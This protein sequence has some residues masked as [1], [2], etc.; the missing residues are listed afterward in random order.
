MEEN[1]FRMLMG[2]L[3]ITAQNIRMLHR[4]LVGGNWFGD[5][6]K[7][8]EYYEKIDDIEDSVTE[9]GLFL[10]Y[11]D[12]T[13]SEASTMFTVLEPKKFTCDEAFSLVKTYFN[14]I[15]EMFGVVKKKC[16][17]PAAVVSKFEEYEYDLML[18]GQY[19]LGRMLTKT[20]GTEEVA[21]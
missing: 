12:I 20:E 2:Y 11:Q 8:G 16:D 17:L 5:H 9:T 21:L 4:H 18:E 14:N 6:E 13:I 10:G 1:A 3:K 19:K 7:L 15:I